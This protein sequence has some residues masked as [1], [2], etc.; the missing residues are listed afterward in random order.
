MKE[1]IPDPINTKIT[2][3]KANHKHKE[4]TLNGFQSHI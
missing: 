4:I 3:E 2:F 1:I